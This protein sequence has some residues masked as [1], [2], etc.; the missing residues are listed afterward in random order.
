MRKISIR[1]TLFAL[2]GILSLVATFLAAEMAL[3]AARVRSAALQAVEDELISDFIIDAQANWARERG[4]TAVALNAVGPVDAKAIEAIAKMRKEGDAAYA[5]ARGHMKSGSHFPEKDKTV[6]AAEA[7]HAKLVEFRKHIDAAMTKK[8]EDRAGAVVGQ[9]V[10][11]ITAAIESLKTVRMSADFSSE[12]TDALLAAY[13]QI[14][15]NLWVVSEYAGRQA[16]QDAG[17]EVSLLSLVVTQ[18]L[19]SN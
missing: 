10:P 6:A 1:T 12:S 15:H 2:I 3:D 14:K 17:K 18:P 11:T 5:E 4:S 9:W 16:H 8:R 19:L 13:A 7:A